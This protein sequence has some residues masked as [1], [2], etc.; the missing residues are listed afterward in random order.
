TSGE[1]ACR[2][3]SPRPSSSACASAVSP[4][5]LVSSWRLPQP[6]ASSLCLKH[7][8]PTATRMKST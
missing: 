5:S 7:M 1:S 3:Q 4:A 6:A 2:M 8:Q